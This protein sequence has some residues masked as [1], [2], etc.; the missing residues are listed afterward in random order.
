MKTKT[1][2]ASFLSLSLML[3]GSMAFAQDTM[4]KDAMG[5]ESMSQDGM[6]KE[7]MA[8]DGMKKDAMAKEHMAKDGMKKD[9]MAKDEMAEPVSMEPGKTNVSVSVSGTVKLIK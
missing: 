9:A 2:A 1:I 7:T 8:K 5:K 4:K 3:S 6:K